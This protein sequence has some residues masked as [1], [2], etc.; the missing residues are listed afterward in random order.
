MGGC[1][2][3]RRP[4]MLAFRHS[5]RHKEGPGPYPNVSGCGAARSGQRPLSQPSTQCRS[6]SLGP[7][8]NKTVKQR[9]QHVGLPLVVFSASVF[10]FRLST[11][12]QLARMIMSSAAHF[13]LKFCNSLWSY[14]T[15]RSPSRS[16]FRRP[17]SLP[18]FLP[19]SIT[20]SLGSSLPQLN[21]PKPQ[22]I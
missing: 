6:R 4:K 20:P 9:Q 5:Y 12:D 13:R 18:I 17:E 19:L 21:G 10:A 14:L 15:L 7:A 8:M 2:T 11:V 3:K 22:R 1:E 16:P